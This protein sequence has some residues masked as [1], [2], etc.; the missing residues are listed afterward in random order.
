MRKERNANCR[1]LFGVLMCSVTVSIVR[2]P[3]GYLIIAAGTDAGER[4]WLCRSNRCNGISPTF[5]PGESTSEVNGRDDSAISCWRREGF[6]FEVWREPWFLIKDFCERIFT[7]VSL[8]LK[9]R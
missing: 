6:I 3:T 5:F 7:S 4:P 2:T 1:K 9:V 8:V